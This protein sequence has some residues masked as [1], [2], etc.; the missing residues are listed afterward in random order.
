MQDEYD[1]S[2]GKRGAVT[3]TSGK[4]R[5]TLFL[6]DDVV[7]AFRERAAASG[8]GCQTLINEALRASFAMTE[9]TNQDF[10]EF[11]MQQAQRGMEDDP[12]IYTD[13]DL[14]ERWR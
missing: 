1:F 3:D 8:I 9:W 4:T 10:S 5:I 11:S 12:V 13:A 6:D 14:R 7:A 2:S